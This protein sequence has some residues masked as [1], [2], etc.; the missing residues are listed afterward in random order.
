MNETAYRMNRMNDCVFKLMYYYDIEK[1][2][3]IFAL[4]T[5]ACTGLQVTN[6]HFEPTELYP[7]NVNSKEV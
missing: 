3:K 1:G 6:V 2:K 5:E 7:E 4:L